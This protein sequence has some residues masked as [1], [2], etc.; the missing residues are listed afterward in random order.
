VFDVKDPNIVFV[1]KF[2]THF[3]G[4]KSIGFGLIYDYAE[5]AK[6]YEPKSGLSGTNLILRLKSQGSK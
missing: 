4:G 2:I 1:F 3:G 5:S 6:E